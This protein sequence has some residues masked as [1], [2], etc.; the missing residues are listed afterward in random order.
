MNNSSLVDIHGSIGVT[1]LVLLVDV[2]A[3]DRIDGS[4][5]GVVARVEVFGEIRTI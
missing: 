1:I 2:C 4:D 5:G 3:I